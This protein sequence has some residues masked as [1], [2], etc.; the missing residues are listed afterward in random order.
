MGNFREKGGFLEFPE[1]RDFLNRLTRIRDFSSDL[2]TI[3]F[4]MPVSALL[5]CTDC[6]YASYKGVEDHVDS[7][8]NPGM[9][10]S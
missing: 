1:S 9:P 3:I 10:L 5:L 8:V 2:D 4:S 6:A 7:I